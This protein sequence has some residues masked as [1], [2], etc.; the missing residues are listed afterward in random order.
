MKG[1]SRKHRR[2]GPRSMQRGYSKNM[3][4]RRLESSKVK[5]G[6]DRKD[7]ASCPL[8]GK[9]SG[10]QIGS[11]MQNAKLPTR[12]AAMAGVPRRRAPSRPGSDGRKRVAQPTGVRSRWW[13]SGPPAPHTCR[14]C[15]RRPAPFTET[16]R[17]S[18]APPRFPSFYLLKMDVRLR[19]SPTK[20]T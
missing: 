9:E 16:D 2:W 10:R 1:G 18:D 19:A 7:S 3:E 17:Q 13:R 20:P 4:A 5:R 15:L 8:H 11:R 12:K 14:R 6:R